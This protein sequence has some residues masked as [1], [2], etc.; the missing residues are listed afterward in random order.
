MIPDLFLGSFRE[1]HMPIP[2]LF[3]VLSPQNPRIKKTRIFALVS[4]RPKVVGSAEMENAARA[5]FRKSR[6]HKRERGG[7]GWEEEKAP[8]EGRREEDAMW[9]QE[10]KANDSSPTPEGKDEEK[11]IPVG[12]VESSGSEIVW[13]AEKIG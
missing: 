12:N 3:A 13:R 1:D 5:E 2:N 11:N 7:R 10:K 6:A 9:K 8:Q 4:L